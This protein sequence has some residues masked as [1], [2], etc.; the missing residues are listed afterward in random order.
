MEHQCTLHLLMGI[1]ERCSSYV[2][3]ALT[4]ISIQSKMVPPLCT[5]LLFTVSWTWHSACVRQDTTLSSA[6]ARRV[7][8]KQQSMS[9]ATRLVLL[10]LITRRLQTM[11]ITTYQAAC[12]ILATRAV[13]PGVRRVHKASGKQPSAQSP[14]LLPS[15]KH[16]YNGIIQ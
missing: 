7:P 16:A 5:Q 10:A 14:A 2:R 4:R 13:R 8:Q 12:A 11:A 15:D 3:L 1:W 9:W 6:R